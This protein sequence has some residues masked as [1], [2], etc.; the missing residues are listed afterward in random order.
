[1]SGDD[2]LTPWHY[3]YGNSCRCGREG[4]HT[5]LGHALDANPAVDRV[6]SQNDRSWKDALVVL[7]DQG[8][9]D[10]E[11]WQGDWLSTLPIPVRRHLVESVATIRGI[12][13]VAPAA[14]PN[15]PEWM[16]IVKA[17]RATKL[18]RPS[19]LLVAEKMGFVTEEPLRTRLRA[20]GV[21]K[22]HAVHALVAAEAT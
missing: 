6:L 16:A 22:W 17:Y 11:I 10:D 3:L 9:T 14:V 19:Q 1:M 5:S 12:E 8:A 18:E 2:I 21:K 13:G 4:S 15:G 7:V 20:L